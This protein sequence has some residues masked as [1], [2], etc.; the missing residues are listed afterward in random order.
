MD[1]RLATKDAFGSTVNVN[2]LYN[3][4]L[5]TEYNTMYCKSSV[6]YIPYLS[7]I[8]TSD[9]WGKRKKAKKEKKRKECKIRSKKRIEEINKK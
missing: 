1:P 7:E 9:S 8:H 2:N 3:C 6:L 4:I 5:R